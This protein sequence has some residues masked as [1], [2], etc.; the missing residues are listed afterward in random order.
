MNV[1]PIRFHQ[2]SQKSL[3]QQVGI[4]PQDT[5]LFNNHLAFNIRYGNMLASDDQVELAAKSADIDDFV[6]SLPEGSLNFLDYFSEIR[7]IIIFLLIKFLNCTFFLSASRI[8]I[9]QLLLLYIFGTFDLYKVSLF[10]KNNVCNTLAPQDMKPWLVRKEWN[11]AGER[12][13]ESQSPEHCWR[14]QRLFC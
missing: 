3:R 5:V 7:L 13:N 1:I 10:K 14:I 6:A 12:S 11:S 9:K 4:V 8:K 2:V